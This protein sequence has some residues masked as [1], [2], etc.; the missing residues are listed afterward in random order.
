VGHP[1]PR[2][3][4]SPYDFGGVRLDPAGELWTPVEIETAEGKRVYA[5]QQ[6]AFAE[7]GHLVR[8]EL[9]TWCD[10]LLAQP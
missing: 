6:R 9:I 10:R 3:A 8:A 1:D 7:R 4:G 2:Y 5:E